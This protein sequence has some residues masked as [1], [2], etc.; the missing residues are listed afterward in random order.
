MQT[1]RPRATLLRSL[2][3]LLLAV[4]LYLGTSA[5]WAPFGGL[6]KRQLNFELPYALV[7]GACLIGFQGFAHRSHRWFSALTL[8][9]PYVIYDSFYHVLDR[10]PRL[11]DF[12]DWANVYRAEPS[13][14]VG[15]LVLGGLWLLLIGYCLVTTYRHAALGRRCLLAVSVA[16]LAASAA[17]CAAGLPLSLQQQ[18][19]AQRVTWD[20][21]RNIRRYGR[22]AD[23]L[24]AQGH[25]VRNRAALA[26]RSAPEPLPN[27][28]LHALKATPPVY[29][30]LLESFTDPR[31]IKGI[32]F[33][34]DPVHLSLLPWL[35]DGAFDLVHVPVYGGGTPQS[36]FEVLAGAPALA[37]YGTIEHNNLR[38]SPMPGFVQ[39]LNAAGYQSEATVATSPRFYNSVRAYSSHGFATPCFIDTCT[40]F[41][42]PTPYHYIHDEDLLAR[43]PRQNDNA[44][45]QYVLGMYGHVNLERHTAIRPDVISLSGEHAGNATLND[46]ANQ[47]YYRT[48]AVGELLQRLQSQQPKAVILVMGDHL[49][50]LFSGGIEYT[51]DKRQSIA[52]LVAAGQRVDISDYHSWQLPY[53]IAAQL[54]GAEPNIPEAAA[55]EAFYHYLMRKGSGL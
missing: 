12:S 50:P 27:F 41:E 10:V 40:G 35:N 31:L 8:L 25:T 45:L 4:L 38:G 5:L 44:H 11:N 23:V 19:M 13:I 20:D 28:G 37:S 1:H 54:S 46:L 14:A 18:L 49:P 52:L 48:K 55:A 36:E 47:F 32:A 3:F 26:S 33:E 30:I 43:Y 21:H 17:L 22:L 9:Y 53:L 2:L 15:M 51:K 39:A 16:G 24:V 34:Q 6:D 7:F 42:T 29:L